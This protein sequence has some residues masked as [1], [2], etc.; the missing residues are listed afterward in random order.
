M[1]EGF[2]DFHAMLL[3]TEEK[4]A[5]MV[6]NEEHGLPHSVTTYVESFVT[7]IRPYPYST[8]MDVNPSTFADVALY[9]GEVHAPGSVFSNMLWEA[10]V[11]M[12]NSDS[13]TF[14]EANSLMKD[15]LLAGY[16]MMPIA[17][18]FVEARDA[19][20]AAAFANEPADAEI[21]LAAFAKRGMG[22]GAVAPSR[23]DTE[24]LDIVESDKTELSSFEVIGQQLNANYEG[25]TSGYCSNDNILDKGE[26]GT[27]SFTI[28][29]RGS[30]FYTDLVAKIEVVGDH[31]IT[32]AN[33]GMTTFASLNP[34]MTSAS[35]PIELI[36]NEAMT[37][38]S[39]ELK[40]S[41]PEL[42]DGVTE[43]YSFTTTVNYDFA[44]RELEGSSQTQNMNTISAFNDFKENVMIGGAGAVGTASLGAWSADDNYLWLN[45]NEYP[46]DVAYETKKMLVGFEAS[47]FQITWYQYYDLEAT[48]DGGVVEVSI[49]DD[50]WIDVTEVG[51]Q[52]VVAG[53]PGVIDSRAESPLADRAAFTGFN[54]GWE[55]VTF[56]QSL[57]GNQVQFRF[58]IASDSNTKAAGWLI[59]DITFDNITSGIFSDVI[60]GDANACDN[61][62]PYIAAV[63]EVE[64]SV[65]EGGSVSLS[66]EASDPN[67]D[68]LTYS[69]EQTAGTAV[70]MTGG[71]T[72]AVSFSAPALASGSEELTFVA[73][74]N[75]GIAT[76]TQS[77]TVTVNNVPEPTPVKKSSSGGSTGLLAFLLLPLA[78]LRRRK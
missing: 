30:V 9:P 4:D 49:N 12:I 13:H 77:F 57:N 33:D 14:A 21:I 23:F 72:A 39:I 43:D 66:V 59:D 15:Y 28:L 32:L 40:I 56:G 17:P 54:Q 38:D 19:I 36:L 70:T 3:L 74:V 7:G 58:R 75:D 34:T 44:E 60:A 10:Y 37:T 35:T 61:R 42:E 68:A 47:D 48:W 50:V 16:K 76:V 53:Y 6:G 62:I 22:L 78:L 5:L 25:L 67:A 2:G 63:S 31:D 26:T 55:R 8:D 18:T 51:G 73:S 27:V 11:G 20:L 45:N 41:F 1:G 64:Q 46:T 69:W 24:F 29:N 71:D 52:F 65:N